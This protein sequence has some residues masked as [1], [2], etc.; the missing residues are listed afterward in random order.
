M[1][2]LDRAA[3]AVIGSGSELN[4]WCVTYFK[5][6]RTRLSHDLDMLRRVV[7]P[8]GS[9]LEVGSSPP[10]FTLAAKLAG[11]EMTGIDLKPERFAKVIEA[12]GLDV[13]ACDIESDH[14]PFDDGAFDVVLFN[15][16]FEH[17]RLNLIH[18]FSELTRVMRPG[19]SLFLSTPNLRSANGLVNLIV[20][21]QAYS[22]SRGL[23]EQYE[24]LSTIGHMGHVRE[25]TVTEVTEFLT[26]F[27]LD[28]Q[29]VVYR[30]RHA[31]GAKR[32]MSRLMPSLRPVFSCIARKPDGDTAA[33]R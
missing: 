7:D 32:M 8:G 9:V 25:Y 6:H 20:R 18:T 27:D 14:Y 17:L 30:G 33:V 11:F 4:D 22:C 26:R 23:Y 16:V 2:L 12:E 21:D 19:G 15:E 3:E 28:I 31:S 29:E 13:R 5:H 1:D 10:L 24:R